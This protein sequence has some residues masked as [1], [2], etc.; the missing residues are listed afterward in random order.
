[1]FGWAAVF[2]YSDS[3]EIKQVELVKI[4]LNA[5]FNDM[6]FRSGVEDVDGSFEKLSMCDS[7][8]GSAKENGALFMES[9]SEEDSATES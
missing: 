4:K 9:E 7:D 2:F 1:M 8:I 6:M 3:D 5:V